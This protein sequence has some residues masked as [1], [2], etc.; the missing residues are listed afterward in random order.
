MLS[1]PKQK[2]AQEA[3][4]DLLQL[5]SSIDRL[6]YLY[7]KYGLSVIKFNEAVQ[8]FEKLIILTRDQKLALQQQ[9]E[10]DEKRQRDS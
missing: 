1:T 9:K 7:N 2:I 4:W 8:S 10:A 5:K 3:N 6:R